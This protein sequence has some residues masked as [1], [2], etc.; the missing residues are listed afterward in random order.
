MDKRIETK[1]IERAVELVKHLDISRVRLR[2]ENL[3]L[4]GPDFATYLFGGK[5][6]PDIVLYKELSENSLNFFPVSKSVYVMGETL[7]FYSK[8]RLNH[9]T[10][11]SFRRT[12]DTQFSSAALL[13]KMFCLNVEQVA[14]S[15][16]AERLYASFSFNDFIVSRQV[17]LSDICDYKEALKSL[18]H[19]KLRKIGHLDLEMEL[20]YLFTDLFIKG[21]LKNNSGTRVKNYI[22]NALKRLTSAVDVVD[23]RCYCR[24]GLQLDL[25]RLGLTRKKSLVSKLNSLRQEGLLFY[26]VNL[27]QQDLAL[28][29]RSLR[30]EL[31]IKSAAACQEL[32]GEEGT[33]CLFD[34]LTESGIFSFRELLKVVVAVKNVVKGNPFAYNYLVKKSLEKVPANKITKKV[35]EDLLKSGVVES[36]PIIFEPWCSAYEILCD[37]AL[38]QEGIEMNI[39]LGFQIRFSNTNGC[40]FF[41]ITTEKGRSTLCIAKRENLHPYLIFDAGPIR[42]NEDDDNTTAGQL[43][44]EFINILAGIFAPLPEDSYSEDFRIVEHR[45]WGN[46]APPEGHDEIA[47]IIVS[48]IQQEAL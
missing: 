9:Y 22:A 37:E 3:Y 10:V 43:L 29:E 24:A 11:V 4:A 33:F 21:K 44:N 35:A 19:S 20:E 30:G 2:F 15:L 48:I 26:F 12:R 14:Y 39:C 18:K 13:A 46:S 38:V 36:R 6:A 7:S 40:R 41:K 47:R 8:Q 16:R 34:S 32:L 28:L 25:L 17:Y 23:I 5:I 42:A 31:S 1:F 27:C 45:G